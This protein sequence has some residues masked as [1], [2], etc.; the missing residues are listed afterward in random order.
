MDVDGRPS[1]YRALVYR[2]NASSASTTTDVGTST[3][4]PGNEK[5]VDNRHP[6]G[7]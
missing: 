5:S 6:G 7:H 4:S 1:A 2:N 3:T